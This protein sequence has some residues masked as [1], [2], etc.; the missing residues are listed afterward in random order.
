[1]REVFCSRA[2]TWL[3]EVILFDFSVPHSHNQRSVD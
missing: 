1:L 2:E 3:A